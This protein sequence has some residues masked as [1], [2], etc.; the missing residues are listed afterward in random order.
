MVGLILWPKSKRSVDFAK[1]KEIAAAAKEAGAIPVGVFVDEDT[2]Q[3][4][5]AKP[6][7]T[8]RQHAWR[9]LANRS[10]RLRLK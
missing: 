1:A 5:S 4:L 2:Q 8:Y 7:P 3:V 6:S 10:A 9:S